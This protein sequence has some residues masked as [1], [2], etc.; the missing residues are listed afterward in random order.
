VTEN[1]IES[2][3]PDCRSYALSFEI[4]I[5]SKNAQKKRIT[6]NKNVSGSPITC[7][8]KE[9]SGNY[10]IKFNNGE[11]IENA[12]LNPVPFCS[13]GLIGLPKKRC[14]K[15]KP[16]WPGVVGMC[17]EKSVD[18]NRELSGHLPLLTCEC[19]A[20][21]L[22]LPDLRV[23]NHAIEVHVAEHRRKEEDSSKAAK[24]ASHI[25]QILIEQLFGKASEMNIR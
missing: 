2:P 11:K 10:T 17:K 3:C 6:K 23:M 25:R 16:T 8:I 13:I 5:P 15:Y 24:T 12:K 9:K 22:L 18:K 19:G 14:F 4:I 20:E 1:L 21:I 7:I